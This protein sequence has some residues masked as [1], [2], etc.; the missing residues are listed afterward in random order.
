[1]SVFPHANNPSNNGHAET[2]GKSRAVTEIGAAR[3]V[4]F[5]ATLVRKNKMRE[6]SMATA[7]GQ[8]TPPDISSVRPSALATG[9]TNAAATNGNGSAYG[10]SLGNGSDNGNGNGHALLHSSGQ[11]LPPA[12]GQPSGSEAT[13]PAE[14]SSG[15]TLQSPGQTISGST[16]EKTNGSVRVKKSAPPPEQLEQFLIN[17]VVE[18]TGYPKEIVELDADLEADLGIDSIK[19]A[20]LFGELRE[21][22]EMTPTEDMTLDDFSTLRHV[23]RFLHQGQEHGDNHQR[24]NPTPDV[25]IRAGETANTIVELTPQSAPATTTTPP[26]NLANAGSA[27]KSAPPIGQLEPFL[28][29]FVVEQT[30]YPA[31]IVEMD[32]DLE[33]DLGI[34]SIKKAQLFGE[35]R[36]YFDITPTEDLTLDDFPTLRHVMDFL[37][38]SQSG[39]SNDS[40]ATPD[41]STPSPTHDAVPLPASRPPAV[42]LP[43]AAVP[44][45]GSDKAPAPDQLEPFLI[46]FV[47]E[48][49]GY[50]AEIVEMDADL[51]ADLGIDS[52]KKAQLFGELREYFDITPTDDLTL[53]DFPTLRDVMNFLQAAHARQQ[54]VSTAETL[55]AQPAG[56]IQ[57]ESGQTTILM[58]AARAGV[59]ATTDASVQTTDKSPPPEELESFLINFVV[60]QTGYP[61]EIVEMDADLEADLGIDSI[62]KAQLFGELREFFEITPTEDLTLDDFATLRDVMS[63][64]QGTHP[65]SK[66][67]TEAVVSSAPT[68]S[69]PGLDDHGNGKPKPGDANSILQAVSQILKE[70][71]M[72]DTV[73]A[74]LTGNTRLIDDVGLDSVGMLDLI[75]AVEKQF[76]IT[77]NLEDLEIE[78]LNRSGTFADLV[79]RKLAEKT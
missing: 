35:L 66:S 18:Q 67:A 15:S 32:A 24:S 10:N 61:A 11:S 46:N 16:N 63:F 79:A 70:R 71:N 75:T 78:S 41:F 3:I 43:V 59:A 68:S 21:Y 76:N 45:P 39:Q 58:P 40:V 52:I 33:A 27:T 13:A 38:G 49:T 22:F 53:D 8:H 57:K 74:N 20:Q 5:D 60:E 29:N 31:E 48:Q 69:T 64:L 50:P 51:E 9:E 55:G 37:Q 72:A 34:D 36:E 14:A 73:K 19:K 26:A 77:I 23:L 2:D 25:S 7:R 1:M 44:A 6:K 28:I 4:Q 12:S 62:K 56:S 17:F 30:G 47:V 65:K 42:H 54:S